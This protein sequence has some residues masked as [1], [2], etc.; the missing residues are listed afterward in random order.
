MYLG[1]DFVFK[2]NNVKEVTNYYQ[3]NKVDGLLIWADNPFIG[4]PVKAAHSL[5]SI[6]NIDLTGKILSTKC[7]N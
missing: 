3:R 2:Y 5:P 7:F 4:S 6:K 1:G